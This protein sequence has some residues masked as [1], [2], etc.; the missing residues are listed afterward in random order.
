MY[1]LPGLK[2]VLR[3]EDKKNMDHFLEKLFGSFDKDTIIRSLKRLDKNNIIAPLS[4]KLLAD[5]IKIKNA[6]SC[7]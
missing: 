1:I 7:K 6:Y 5:A 2:I 3:V 4:Q